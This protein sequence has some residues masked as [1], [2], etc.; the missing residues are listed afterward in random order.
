M[1]YSK[2]NG[3]WHLRDDNSLIVEKIVEKTGKC[4]QYEFLQV[5]RKSSWTTFKIIFGTLSALGA[6]H[7]TI[8]GGV[9][10][11][12]SMIFELFLE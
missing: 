1:Y 9:V 8:I 2:V 4:N 10:Y 12:K 3:P 6:C 5:L 7:V 11:K